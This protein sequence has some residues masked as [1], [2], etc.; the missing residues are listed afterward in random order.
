MYKIWL[1][2]GIV[3]ISIFP[4]TNYAQSVHWLDGE[5]R[6]YD[7]LDLSKADTTGWVH[8][9]DEYVQIGD[10]VPDSLDTASYTRS[11]KV[12]PEHKILIVH[13]IL[14]CQEGHTADDGWEY[15]LF[16]VNNCNYDTRGQ[17]DEVKLEFTSMIN[18]SNVDTINISIKAIDCGYNAHY[19]NC[20]FALGCMN[21][22]TTQKYVCDNDERVILSM[23]EYFESYR[24]YDET[25]PT[26][27]LGFTNKLIVPANQ[28]K[29]YRCRVSLTGQVLVCG[30]FDLAMTDATDDVIECHAFHQVDT[31][32]IPSNTGQYEWRGKTY[33]GPGIWHDS[34]QSN[35]MCD[36]VYTLVL[37]RSVDIYERD[38]ICHNSTYFW[39]NK[40]C[41]KGVYFTDTIHTEAVDTVYHLFLE[42]LPEYGYS[43][44]TYD[45]ICSNQNYEWRGHRYS[46]P[47]HYVD[48]LLAQNGC[49]S[50]YHLYLH[51]RTS[52]ITSFV[53]TKC[54]GETI[55]VNGQY[56]SSPCTILDTLV[57]KNG[58]DSIIKTI[59]QDEVCE[60][61]DIPLNPWVDC[62]TTYGDT[63]AYICYTD[64]PF[65]WRGRVAQ[66]SDTIMILNY[67]E[68]DSVV[69]LHLKI[70]PKPDSIMSDTTLC[71]KSILEWRGYI[72]DSAGL[73]I[74]TVRTTDSLMCD[75][76]YYLLN[77]QYEVCPCDTA[78]T[79]IYR[80]IDE[81]EIPY[82]WE[83]HHVL[84]HIPYNA[85]QDTT[86]IYQT[87]KE[88]LSC[89][90]IATLHLHVLLPCELPATYLPVRWPGKEN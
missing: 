81:K 54:P 48:S 23:P 76:V 40:D 14:Y 29:T 32:Y 18:V 88:D 2:I 75:S 41:S 89:D 27:A 1:V 42:R 10:V 19:V 62:D 33:T 84:P 90:S 69:T 31:A 55:K 17:F 45:T 16:S 64:L 63:T 82:T 70:S 68:C 39:R 59:I 44:E 71:E 74:D 53:Y 35:C 52:P 34:L 3:L 36:S 72:I 49:D 24:W 21:S 28:G 80:Q 13:G 83:D 73:Y 67:V 85:Q 26:V 47:G 65:I 8:L 5:E 38:T 61:R 79:H 6:C 20:R 78:F 86:F 46:E 77:V 4:I 50:L 7:Y 37:R 66:D 12:S 15:I 58:C 56:Y 51:V 9:S 11:F 25:N 43:F 22:I 87:V 60:G 57:A 30:D